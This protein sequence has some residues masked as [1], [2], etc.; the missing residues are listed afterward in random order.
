[1]STSADPLTSLKFALERESI[2]PTIIPSSFQ[3]TL[4]FA[5]KYPPDVEVLLGNKLTVEQ[6]R[7]EP[8]VVVVPMSV[9]EVVADG[10]GKEGEEGRRGYSTKEDVSYTLVMTDPDAPSRDD[11]KFGPF[12]HWVV[13]RFQL[14][15]LNGSHYSVLINEEWCALWTSGRC[16]NDVINV[17]GDGSENPDR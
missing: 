10:D 4:L 2:I 13:S 3:P 12:R 17:I 7:E 1:M 16:V 15:C 11:P 14:R 6:T 5:I 8:S 9:P